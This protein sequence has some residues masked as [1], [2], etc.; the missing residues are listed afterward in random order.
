[1]VEAPCIDVAKPDI[2]QE[3]EALARDV[4]RRVHNLILPLADLL[5]RI[6]GHEAIDTADALLMDVNRADG[7]WLGDGPRPAMGELLA[8][9]SDSLDAATKAL[10][11]A[12]TDGS[13][14]INAARCLLRE[15]LP[16]AVDLS[17]AFRSCRLAGDSSALRALQ[18]RKQA[19]YAPARDPGPASAQEET[20]EHHV[21]SAIA[22]QASI[23]LNVV[24]SAGRTA[25]INEIRGVLDAARLL[26]ATIGSLADGMTGENKRG[27]QYGWHNACQN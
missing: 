24:D 21:L 19:V 11:A 23:L 4:A 25:N 18:E 22:L 10:S 5:P 1:M 15:A 16:L 6:P 7:T 8:M 13:D 9:V 26:T 12:E 27:D 20:K 17:S 3:H 2:L 14:P